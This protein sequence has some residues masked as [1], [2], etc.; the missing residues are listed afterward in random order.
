MA[1]LIVKRAEHISTNDYQVEI[2][3]LPRHLD[4]SS[5]QLRNIGQ[6]KKTAKLNFLMTEEITDGKKLPGHLNR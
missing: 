4:V 6:V 1:L 3:V 2:A 5:L